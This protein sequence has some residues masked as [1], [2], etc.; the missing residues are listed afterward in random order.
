ML[1]IDT[2]FLNNLEKILTKYRTLE[3]KLATELP[4]EEFA[5]ASKEYSDLGDIV[6]QILEYKKNLQEYS[7]LEQILATETDEELKELAQT[8]CQLLHDKIPTLEHN[9]KI[10]LLPK[11][12]TDEKNAI[13]EIRAGAGGQEAAL[14]AAQLFNM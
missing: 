7:D 2:T 9:I 5:H 8:E 3:T 12:E 11:D 10:A 6:A 4:R 14:F 13:I 1:N